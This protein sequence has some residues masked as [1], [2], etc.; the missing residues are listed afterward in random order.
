MSKNRQDE[1]RVIEFTALDLHNDATT[2]DGAWAIEFLTQKIQEAIANLGLQGVVQRQLQ[3]RDLTVPPLKENSPSKAHYETSQRGNSNKQEKVLMDQETEPQDDSQSFDLDDGEDMHLDRL[4]TIL[5]QLLTQLRQDRA[6]VTRELA[7]AINSLR[8]GVQTYQIDVADVQ[9]CKLEKQVFLVGRHLAGI[10]VQW[11]KLSGLIIRLSN[12]LDR[13]QTAC[14]L[15]DTKTSE[16]RFV[17]TCEIDPGHLPYHLLDCGDGASFLCHM[18]KLKAAAA[19]LKANKDAR[20][21]GKQQNREENRQ[22]IM[23]V[24]VTVSMGGG[25]IDIALLGSIQE[26][27]EKETLAWNCSIE[28]GG[29]LLHVHLQMVLRMW[30]TSLVAINRMI[31]SYLCWADVAPQGGVVICRALTKRKLH[32]FEG[33]I[34]CSLK[35]NG[36]L[37]FQMVQHNITAKQINQRIE[38]HMRYDCDEVK[39]R[40]CLTSANI[41][42]RAHMFLKYSSR[43]PVG[44]DFLSTL[45]EMIKGGKY[46]PTSSW[47]TPHQGKGMEKAKIAA[48]WTCVV[49]PSTITYHDILRIFVNDDMYSNTPP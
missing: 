16:R 4:H 34:G 2:P 42:D 28:R 43:H 37:Y 9:V 6:I 30:S 11:N 8:D 48:L 40:V 39:N 14:F 21:I 49:Y 45:H 12:A 26:F 35:D 10:K 18:A 3:A 15:C 41:F 5:L 33:M 20:S 31:K 7:N 36:Q 47:I 17:L 23:E 46:Y 1:E 25:D 29:T 44:N 13:A 19:R 32:T 38:L 27:L 22:K 24:S